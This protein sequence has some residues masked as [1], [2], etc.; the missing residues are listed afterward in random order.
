MPSPGTG[1]RTAHQESVSIAGNSG[2]KSSLNND[3]KKN[4]GPWLGAQL[5][6]ASS[7][8]LK[9]CEFDHQSGHVAKLQV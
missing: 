5:F 3:L 1:Q 6:G 8:T 4:L 7:H 9:G 2:M